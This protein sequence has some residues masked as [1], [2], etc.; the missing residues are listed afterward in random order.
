MGLVCTGD[1]S[2]ENS[3]PRQ[4]EERASQV[5]G[6][7]GT[8]DNWGVIANRDI[9]NGEVITIFGG[10]T[11][12]NGSE[13]VTADFGQLHA[14]LHEAGEPLQYTLQG[15]LAESSKT[16][17]WA[18]PEPDKEA[19]RGR[20]DVK[21][22]LRQALAKGGDSGIGQW[23]NHTCCDT[24]CNA[25][26]Q[27]TRALSGDPRQDS[28]DE[29]GVIMLVVRASKP[30]Q[31]HETILVHYNPRSGIQSWGKV[32]KCTCCLCRG[33]CGPSALSSDNPE[34]SFARLIKQTNHTGAPSDVEISKGDFVS[35]PQK[36]FW[37]NVDE[38]LTGSAKVR[39]FCAKSRK[40]I[41]REV[42]LTEFQKEVPLLKWKGAVKV[43]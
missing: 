26:F 15:R 10:T 21:K 5:R 32:F 7:D 6:L 29:E 24:H 8:A 33:I 23:I 16:K 20:R 37:G 36:D 17:I 19:V 39:G 41:S 28:M 25:E 27:L 40:L 35:T 13:R 38:P 18:I 30:I 34:Q 22:S 1:C 12:L 42:R 3:V 43:S 14:R 4:E 2:C 31:R 9:Q 11:Y